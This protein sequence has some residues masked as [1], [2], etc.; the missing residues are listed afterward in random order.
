MNGRTFPSVTG[1]PEPTR[2][3]VSNGSTV[4]TRIASSAT[5]TTNA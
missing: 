5:S 3:T 2:A 4:N 1:S